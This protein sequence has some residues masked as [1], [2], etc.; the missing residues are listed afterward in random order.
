MIKNRISI[1]FKLQ[2]SFGLFKSYNQNLTYLNQNT[3]TQKM[4]DW[5]QNV[6]YPILD[7]KIGYRFGFEK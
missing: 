7:L 4:S 1:D 3:T 5:F 6:S 2:E